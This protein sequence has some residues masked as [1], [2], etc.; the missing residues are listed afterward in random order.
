M[1]VYSTSHILSQSGHA[2]TWGNWSLDIDTFTLSHTNGYWLPLEGDV[3]GW[4]FHVGMKQW[5]TGRDLHDLERAFVAS[6]A[7]QEVA[8]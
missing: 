6:R 5:A 2:S 8:A 1:I 3:E 7:I 4:V